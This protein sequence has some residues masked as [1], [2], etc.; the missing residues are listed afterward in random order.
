MWGFV[1]RCPEVGVDGGEIVGG[2]GGW[3]CL[4]SS[5]ARG[6]MVRNASERPVL[7]R[8]GLP[9]GVFVLVYILSVTIARYLSI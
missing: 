6:G 2:G 8:F 4:V 3:W 7:F 5:V 1:F 9:S